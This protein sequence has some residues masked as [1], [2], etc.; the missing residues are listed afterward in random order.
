M[1]NHKVEIVRVRPEKHP[2]AD[3]L[4]I[5]KVYG[6]DCVSQIGQFKD[7]DLAAYIPPDSVVDTDRPEF[8]FLKRDKRFERIKARKFRGQWSQ[9]L[10]IPAPP[11]SVIGQDVASLL[12]VEHYEPQPFKDQVFKSLGV[13]GDNCHGPEIPKYDL[14]NWRRYPDIFQNGDEILVTEKIHGANARIYSDVDKLYVG[15]R[16]Q[17]KKEFP[18]YSHLKF[19]ELVPRVGEEKAKDI[20]ERITSKPK[21]NSWWEALSIH[22]EIKEFCLSNPGICVYAELYGSVQNLK[23]GVPN[24]QYRLA[25]FD[26]W[27]QGKGFISS[28]DARSMA[29]KLPWV[30]IIFMGSYDKFFIE[31]LSEGPSLIPGAEHYREG[32]VIKPLRNERFHPGLGRVALKLVSNTYLEKN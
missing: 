29:P 7:G 27:Q 30:P 21:R 26:L 19:E 10:L 18:D 16:T 15:S 14:E 5:I 25:V 12:E 13:F 20:I 11:G 23:Y 2:N 28:I 22:P 24:G 6:Y 8:Y 32:C 9:G 4:E 17:W 1:S 3:A 31:K